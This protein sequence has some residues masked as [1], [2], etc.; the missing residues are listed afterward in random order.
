MWERERGGRAGVERGRWREREMD[1][2]RKEGVM[3]TERG[4]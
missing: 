1:R 4:R 3:E 2:A